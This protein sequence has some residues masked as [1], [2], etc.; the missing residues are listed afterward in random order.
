MIINTKN[1]ELLRRMIRESKKFDEFSFNE[2]SLEFILDSLTNN[3]E[4]LG[5]LMIDSATNTNDINLHNLGNHLVRSNQNFEKDFQLS[6]ASTINLEL[7]RLFLSILI[8]DD[9]NS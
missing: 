7:V 1:A 4:N 5:H 2:H 8:V 9:E 6:K 3:D